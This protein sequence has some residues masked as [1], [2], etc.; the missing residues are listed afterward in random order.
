MVAAACFDC[1]H[2]GQDFVVAVLVAGLA[3]VVERAVVERVA[4]GSVAESV[5]ELVV[6]L[7]V[8]PAMYNHVGFAL[9][10]AVNFVDKT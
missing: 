2:N 4:V 1:S 5:V 3:H 8:V 9:A 7:V 10:S 6:E